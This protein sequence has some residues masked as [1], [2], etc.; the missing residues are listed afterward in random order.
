VR[1]LRLGDRGKEVS[2]VQQ[3]LFALSYDLGGEGL[4]GFLGPHTAQAIK[5]FQQQRGLLV[6]GV[7]GDNTWRELVEAGYRLGDRL[8]Y[9]RVPH[10]RGDDVL[11]LQVK[12]NLLGFNAGPERGIFDQA[13][14]GAVKDFQHNAGLLPDGIVGGSTLLK[15]DA[16]RKA[17]SGREGKK[18]P[19]RDRGFAP[20]R[21]LTG[22][23][24]VIDPGHGGRDRGWMS[25]GG[26]AEKDYTLQ[27]GLRLAQLLRAEGSRVHLTRE[28]DEYVGVYE[29]A[30]IADGFGADFLLSLHA[31]GDGS[32]DVS[33]AACY[34]FRR[35][36]YYS[37]HGERLAGYVGARLA[38]L[39][40]GFAGS[41]GRNYAILREP[42]A[43]ALIV[44]P[45]FLT[46]SQAEMLALQPQHVDR[47][48]GAVTGGLNDY[49]ARVPLSPEDEQTEER[50]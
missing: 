4:D 12:L 34:Y 8:L 45:L 35:G 50:S 11:A 19:E 2:D 47:L 16:L 10:F 38:E 24:I 43:V 28:R 17:E 33:T 42:H 13:V 14:D 26:L 36:H 41:L 27:I 7:I 18:I 22:Q 30:E 1:T 25:A 48:A 23:T 32:P 44:E 49:L 5:A 6:D 39:G 3:R 40:L 31:G 15:L 9:L 21:E 46:V 20:V 29:R 37:E